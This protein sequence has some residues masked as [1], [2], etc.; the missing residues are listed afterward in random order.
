MKKYQE[1]ARVIPT[2]VDL[3]CDACGKSCKTALGDYEHATLKA[4]WG[5][6]SRKDG[7]TCEIELCEDCFDDLIK[8]VET[9]KKQNGCGK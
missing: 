4:C 8:H 1:Q 9:R 5:Y 7:T 6:S 2:L 3:S